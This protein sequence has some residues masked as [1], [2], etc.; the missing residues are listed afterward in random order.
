MT[1]ISDY[2]NY[3]ASVKQVYEKGDNHHDAIL[4]NWQISYVNRG[5]LA[6]AFIIVT[7]DIYEDSKNRFAEGLNIHTSYVK[8]IYHHENEGLMV[9]TANT[10]YKLVT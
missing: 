7:G 5:S 8:R 2:Q 1:K 6:D 4:R 10:I 9:Q 3:P